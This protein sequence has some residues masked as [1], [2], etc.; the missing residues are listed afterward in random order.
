MDSAI[1]E[2]TTL[3]E[4]KQRLKRVSVTSSVSEQTKRVE[5]NDISFVFSLMC[6]L[7]I[8]LDC[9]EAPS[10]PSTWPQPQREEIAPSFSSL[11]ATGDYFKLIHPWFTKGP[12]GNS[13]IPYAS[14]HRDLP[15]HPIFVR[16]LLETS[17]S[18]VRALLFSTW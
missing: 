12:R 14:Y 10:R 13:T 16:T 1:A 3:L 2:D 9:F 8:T 15:I 7:V 18:K 17:I 11:P 6:S 5:I 4:E